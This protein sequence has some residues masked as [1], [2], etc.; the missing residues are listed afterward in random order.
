MDQLYLQ[1]EMI[2]PVF[3]GK[4]QAWREMSNGWVFSRVAG[5]Y[6]GGR[7]EL[8]HVEHTHSDS[9]VGARGGA[10]D[11]GAKDNGA[12]DNGAR[13]SGAK[14]I[15]GLVADAVQVAQVV[16]WASI[17][18]RER[19]VEKVSRSYNND[20]CRLVDVVRQ[21]LVFDQVP[22]LYQHCTIMV[23][24]LGAHPYQH[25]THHS[26]FD[27]VPTSNTCLCLHEQKLCA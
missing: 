23:C 3:L 4:V 13:D 1:A 5:C 18:G 10:K 22:N 25:H 6:V 2:W 19:A 21:S 12:K 8:A 7:Q 9:A 16:H 17:K 20:V 11:N 24:L 26:L 27:A 14:D 15:G